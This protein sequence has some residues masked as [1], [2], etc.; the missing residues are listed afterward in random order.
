MPCSGKP[1][2]SGPDI[3]KANNASKRVLN[4]RYASGT[5]G[6]E[7]WTQAARESSQG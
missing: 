7:E 2:S 4:R 3:V 1:Y 5:T 6:R